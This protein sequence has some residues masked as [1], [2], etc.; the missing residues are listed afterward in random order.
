M[1][2]DK[3]QKK[4]ARKAL[5]YSCNGARLLSYMT[6]HE[7]RHILDIPPARRTTCNC[8]LPLRDAAALARAAVAA[9]G[10]AAKV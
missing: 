5:G 9:Y 3:A 10:R 7:A 1:I 4:N 8:P 2:D 6:H